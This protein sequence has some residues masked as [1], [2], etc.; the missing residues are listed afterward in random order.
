MLINDVFV[1]SERLLMTAQQDEADMIN[2]SL[3]AQLQSVRG[4]R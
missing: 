3:K 1:L 2:E 4:N